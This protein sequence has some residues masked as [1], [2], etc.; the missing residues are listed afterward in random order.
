MEE[1]EGGGE[2][3]RESAEGVMGEIRRE[4]ERGEGREWGDGEGRG[5][6]RERGKGRGR[7]GKTV[8]ILLYSEATTM[9]TCCWIYTHKEIRN[10][11]FIIR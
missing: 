3:Q 8:P 7:T 10:A 5:R 6:G 1:G 11:T 4:G 9:L 2:L